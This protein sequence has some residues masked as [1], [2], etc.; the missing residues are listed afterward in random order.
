MR[1]YDVIVIGA[2][3][4]GSAAAYALARDQR[5]LLLEQH[6]FLHTHGSSHG[7]SRIFRYAYPQPQYVA[8]ARAA[9]EGWRALEHDVG[10][11]VLT[12]TGGLDIGPAGSE[13]L[14]Q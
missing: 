7:G 2:G 11:N 1:N 9:E 3:V 14:A 12:T 5:V 8:L 10:E 6:R 13:G 4:A